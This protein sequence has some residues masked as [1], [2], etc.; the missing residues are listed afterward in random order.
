MGGVAP[1]VFKGDGRRGHRGQ[2]SQFLS[3]P[4]TVGRSWPS[5]QGLI[6]GPLCEV[7]VVPYWHAAVS[8][9]AAFMRLTRECRQALAIT[10]KLVLSQEGRLIT[11][12]AGAPN[13]TG[14]VCIIRM[15]LSTSPRDRQKSRMPSSA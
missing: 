4:G 9:S 6:P 12:F 3:F 15:L 14:R 1:Y 7:T 11:F 2:F 13:K 10:V 8:P 5:Q